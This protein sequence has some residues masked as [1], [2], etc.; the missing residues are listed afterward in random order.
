MNGRSRTAQPRTLSM[1]KVNQAPPQTE[2]RAGPRTT[3]QLAIEYRV[4]TK[5]QHDMLRP[6]YLTVPTR[7]RESSS[8]TG[9]AQPT[10]LSAASADQTVIQQLLALHEKMD[11]L[12]GFLT[13]ERL[14]GQ[15]L[16]GLPVERAMCVEL[17]A[18]GLRMAGY[19]RAGA[20][21]FL[22]LSLHLPEGTTPAVTMIGQLV[23]E[24]TM[25]SQDEKQAG[26]VFTAAHQED[27][28][29]IN[30]YISHGQS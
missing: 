24:M 26:I 7:L 8:P 3:C 6:L 17:G 15:S 13:H 20:G 27:R 25:S 2:R 10:E 5:S 12:I 30:R 11:A 16:D 29:A 14:S 28:A 4:L 22:E 21:D 23:Y 1:P 9:L 18:N 19:R